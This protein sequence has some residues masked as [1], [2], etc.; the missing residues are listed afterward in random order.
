MTRRQRVARA[1]FWF[2][3]S[4]A[5]TLVRAAVELTEPVYYAPVSLLDYTAVVLTS[6]ASGALAVALYSWWRTA[7]FARLSIVLLVAAIAIAAESLGNLLEDGFDSEF[8]ATLYT[9]GGL[10]GAV[11]LIVTA[12]V[13]L[14]TASP[15]RWSGLFLLAGLGGA[16]FPDDGGLWLTGASFSGLGLWMIRRPAHERATDEAVR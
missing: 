10:I 15:M 2:I 9:N 1:G 16:I 8:G 3:A 11:A 6:A 13:A 7:P 5:L 12:V 4:G 14:A